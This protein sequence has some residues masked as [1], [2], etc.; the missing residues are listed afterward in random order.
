MLWPE[1]ACWRFVLDRAKGVGQLYDLE[2]DA[3]EAH[4]LAWETGGQEI[5]QKMR[6]RLV[7]QMI[8]FGDDGPESQKLIRQIT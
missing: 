3:H 4:N 1:I 2:R 6:V 5:L 8:E 7:Q